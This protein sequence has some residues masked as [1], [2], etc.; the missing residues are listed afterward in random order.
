[1]Y[2]LPNSFLFCLDFAIFVGLTLILYLC[3][4]YFLFFLLKTQKRPIICCIFSIINCRLLPQ[5][6]F[7]HYVFIFI[8]IF[9]IIISTSISCACY[10]LLYSKVVFTVNYLLIIIEGE[11]GSA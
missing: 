2:V 1:V 5:L 6:H 9:M 11:L 8:I 3:S 7:T 4:I 10:W